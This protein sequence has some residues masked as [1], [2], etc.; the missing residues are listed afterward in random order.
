M[1]S[2]RLRRLDCLRRVQSRRRPSLNV[3][4]DKPTWRA[5]KLD[6]GLPLRGDT[7]LRL[8]ETVDALAAAPRDKDTPIVFSGG[9]RGVHRAWTAA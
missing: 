9:P 7:K 4:D 5:V 3:T 1:R 6:A 2:P 8:L